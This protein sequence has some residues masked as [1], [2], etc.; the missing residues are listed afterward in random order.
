MEH[1]VLNA[2]HAGAVNHHHTFAFH[3]SAIDALKQIRIVVSIV[4][5][6]WV[7]NTTVRSLFAFLAPLAVHHNFFNRTRPRN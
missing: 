1:F 3:P 5:I 6:G 4:V 7:A 2:N